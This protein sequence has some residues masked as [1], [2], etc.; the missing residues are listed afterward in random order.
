MQKRRHFALQN[1]D[2]DDDDVPLHR[3]QPFGA[4]LKRKRV[5]FVPAKDA[6]SNITA[7]I[8]D[9]NGTKGRVL[10]GDIYASIVLGTAAAA[11]KRPASVSVS[12]APSNSIN[13]E[14]EE[15]QSE[16]STAFAEE[17]VN[18]SGVC[19]VC[20]LPITTSIRE[21]EASLAHQVSLTHSHPPSALDRSRMGL[22]TLAAQGWDPDARTGL[23]RGGE[24]A[25][26]PIKVTAKEDTLGI[27]AE[28]P[29]REQIAASAAA[30]QAKKPLSAK[31]RKA[32]DL[33][34]KKRAERLQAEIF[35]SV[36]VD[37]Y[38]RGDGTG[39]S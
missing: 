17:L 7:T 36:D 4:G 25:R 38:L 30:A 12:A 13:T 33:K 37:R 1:E 29:T 22:R 9:G 26:F 8:L 14:G 21:H 32:M 18:A 28:P 11:P 31:E 35:G 20:S 5:E 34:D 2:D 10:A 24:G 3:K 6:D 15:L 19:K 27:G 39:N 16:S 23:G